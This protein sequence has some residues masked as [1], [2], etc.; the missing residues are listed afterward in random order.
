MNVLWVVRIHALIKSGLQSEVEKN[1]ENAGWNCECWSGCSGRPDCIAPLE[2][3]RP[4][5]NHSPQW[6]RGRLARN[7]SPH[8]ALDSPLKAAGRKPSGYE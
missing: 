6:E 5:R 2:R 8:P 1:W 3:G 4:A 7:H